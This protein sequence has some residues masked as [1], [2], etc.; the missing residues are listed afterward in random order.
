[1]NT[2][3]NDEVVEIPGTGTPPLRLREKVEIEGREYHF[4]SYVVTNRTMEIVYTTDDGRYNYQGIPPGAVV[5]LE[6]KP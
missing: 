6:G 1:M 2:Q 3:N 5:D 4:K